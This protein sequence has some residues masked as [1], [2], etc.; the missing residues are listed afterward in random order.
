MNYRKI[1]DEIIERAVLEGRTKG[2]P[3]YYESH[4]IIPKCIGGTNDKSNLVLL[5][6]R[7]HFIV[8]KLLVEL[9]PSNKKLTYAWIVMCMPLNK[10]PRTYRVSSREFER[11]RS[12]KSQL[13]AQ[14]NVARASTVYQYTLDGTFINS[15]VSSPEAARSLNLDPSDIRRCCSGNRSTVGG[16]IFTYMQD[17]DTVVGKVLQAQ[18]AKKNS[19]TGIRSA[20]LKRS[21][22]VEQFDLQGMLIVRFASLSEASRVTNIQHAKIRHWCNNRIRLEDGSF[23]KF[24]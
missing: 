21:R 1:H 4:H 20:I 13:R 11:A 7:E 8:H 10:L 16:F 9:Y 23:W 22:P 24:A 18:Q 6:A 5:T 12:Q 3:I 17:S 14:T 19:K 2:G 15:Y